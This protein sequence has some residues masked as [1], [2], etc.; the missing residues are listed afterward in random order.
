MN[1]ESLFESCAQ[2]MCVLD[3]HNI[4]V[5]VRIPLIKIYSSNTYLPKSTYLY[6]QLLKSLIVAT[7]KEIMPTFKRNQ[8]FFSYQ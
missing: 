5:S 1:I 6:R 2:A 8:T 3:S 4:S 7:S